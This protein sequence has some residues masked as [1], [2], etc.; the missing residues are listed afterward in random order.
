MPPTPSTKKITYKNNVER[1]VMIAIVAKF[2]YFD[3]INAFN[4]SKV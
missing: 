1:I 4:L 2:I 3:L